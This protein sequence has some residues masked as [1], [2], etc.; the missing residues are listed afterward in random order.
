MNAETLQ[1][2]A[3]RLEVTLE[4]L[5][6]DIYTLCAWMEKEGNRGYSELQL[7]EAALPTYFLTA[8]KALLDDMLFHAIPG[9]K[10]GE[11]SGWGVRRHPMLG[12]VMAWEVNW[13]RRFQHL[14][15]ELVKQVKAKIEDARNPSIKEGAWVKYQDE[16]Y[17]VKRIMQGGIYFVESI[18]GDTQMPT[19]ME[20]E[21]VHAPRR[22]RETFSG[23]HFSQYTTFDI[24]YRAACAE[25]L[26][27]WY[28]CGFMN[29]EE[30]TKRTYPHK[31]CAAQWYHEYNVL[32]D[33]LI[34][35][36]HAAPP[37]ESSKK[38]TQATA[39]DWAKAEAYRKNP[40]PHFF[41]KDFVDAVTQS[42]EYPD[43]AIDPEHL[44]KLLP[45]KTPMKWKSDREIFADLAT[46]LNAEID[47][48]SFEFE[49]RKTFVDMARRWLMT[50]KGEKATHDHVAAK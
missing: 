9:K 28:Q 5:A 42:P 6:A 7:K 47:P 31:A 10:K 35:R 49:D 48:D 17:Q 44:P 33:E 37:I 27:R 36:M 40:V 18:Y 13:L 26:A 16:V 38:K 22:K 24:A 32:M 20:I 15:I 41:S 14:E 4:A 25:V 29:R 39:A 45:E 8:D 30:S 23:G 50:A 46:W 2:I 21:L 19:R 3:Q 12:H 11:Y 43:L 1:E 34:Y